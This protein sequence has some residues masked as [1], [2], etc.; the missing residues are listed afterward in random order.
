MGSA[1][2]GS[3]PLGPVEVSGD[4]DTQRTQGRVI[5]KLSLQQPS[6]LAPGHAKR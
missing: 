6:F 3:G 1:S 2:E 4:G 5:A